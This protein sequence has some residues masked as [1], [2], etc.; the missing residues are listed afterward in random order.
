V[1]VHATDV[2]GDALRFSLQPLP[3]GASFD[4]ETGTLAWTPAAA[5]PHEFECSVSDGSSTARRTITVNV[6]A[7]RAP[8]PM[9]EDSLTIVVR[10]GH[11]DETSD[12]IHTRAGSSVLAFDHD[13][14]AVTVRPRRL[15]AGARLELSENRS[16]VE[17][18]FA[19]TEA[20][21][22]EHEL[23]FDVSDG[24]LTTRVERRITVLPAWAAR[25]SSRWLLLGGGPAAY[26]TPSEGEVFIGGA[27]DVTLLAVRTSGVKA[28]RCANGADPDECTASHHR[29]YAEF[30]VLDSLRAGSPSLFTYGLG[31]SG[32]LEVNPA[33]R[34]LIPQYGFE[35]GGLIGAAAGHLLAT[36]PYLG[37]HLVANDD[38]WLDAVLGYRVVPA[39]LA[40]LSGPTLGVKLVLAPW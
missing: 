11:R 3:S 17:L 1:V 10:P 2:D 26:L 39:E 25:R 21:V 23:S 18:H 12:L 35:V 19:P 29:F 14:D 34:Y 13:M 32:S 40:S 15:P 20:Q 8:E 22:G 5:G 27:F 6:G 36:R 9:G 30:E 4:T 38:L 7:N 16:G 37:L 33:R 28:A 31:Y 24:E